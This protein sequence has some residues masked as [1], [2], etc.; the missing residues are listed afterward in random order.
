MLKVEGL[1]KNYGGGW[2]RTPVTAVRSATF[3]IARGE[4]L[5]LIGESGS[6]KTTVARMVSRLLQPSSGRITFDGIDIG[7]IAPGRFSRSPM[8][9]LIQHVFQDPDDALTP[10]LTAFDAIAEPLRR[11][12]KPHDLSRQVEELADAVFL[13]RSVLQRYPHQLSGGQKARIGIARALAPQP[14][15][16]VLDEPTASLD[17]SVQAGILKLLDELRSALGL[18]F[19]FVTH[20]I[21]VVKLMCSRFVLMQHG[22]VVEAGDVASFLRHPQSSYGRALLDAIPRFSSTSISS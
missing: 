8:R 15:L 4:S 19:L 18:S 9:R 1:G 5:A 12:D 20:D 16:L 3:E 14:R 13:P 2:G 11:L 6:G 22:D 17:V 10:H 7:D 21:E